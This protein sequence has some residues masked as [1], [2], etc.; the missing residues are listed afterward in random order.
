[1]SNDREPRP[2]GPVVDYKAPPYPQRI[3]HVGQHVVL[4]PLDPAVDAAALYPLTHAPTGDPTIWD[5]LWEGPFP[6]V[7]SYQRKLEEQAASD[8]QL[9][10]TVTNRVDGKDGP[11]PG[12]PLGVLALMSTVPE[13]GRIEVGNVYFSPSL[14]RTPAATESIFL[15]G[16][17]V[18]DELG[19]RRFEW[20]CNALN[21]PSRRAA[22]RYG[23]LFE[24]VFAQHMIIK[25]RNRDTAWFAITDA[26]WP[27][28]REAFE[29]WLAPENFDAD[30]VQRQSL[31]KLTGAVA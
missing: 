17:H 3:N 9:F 27:A 5:Y 4:R 16:R 24:G 23:F 19:Y 1:M 18:I 6:D 12:E 22:L 10:F 25:G 30:G 14:Q 15:L 13:H 2:I 29:T 20:K 31:S 8:D 11:E 26:R 21:A 7:E 28:V